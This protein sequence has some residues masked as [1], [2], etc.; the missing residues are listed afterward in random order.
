MLSH[1]LH[2]AAASWFT[3]YDYPCLGPAPGQS[4]AAD[5]DVCKLASVPF[6][7]VSCSDAAGSQ[8]CY[9]DVM[10]SE[11]APHAPSN[12]YGLLQVSRSPLLPSNVLPTFAAPNCAGKM[13]QVKV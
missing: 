3:A 5:V 12:P 7:G 6:R 2:A 13:L 1:V 10:K 4:A 11:C 8:K 9:Y